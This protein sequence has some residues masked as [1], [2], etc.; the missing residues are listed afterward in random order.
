MVAGLPGAYVYRG[1]NTLDAMIGYRGEHEYLGKLAARLDDAANYVPARLAG[2]L[3]CAVAMVGERSG[4]SRG[5]GGRHRGRAALAE[6]RRSHGLS[7]SP[8]KMWTI[9]PMAGLLGVCLEK[10]GHCR[11]GDGDDR[12]GGRPLT[13]E[14]IGEASAVIW[15]A[16][17]GTLVAAALAAALRAGLRQ[18]KR[19]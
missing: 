5:R 11:I 1:I 2:G 6:L 7:D 3:L 16:G 15:K 8:N 4:A 14:V 17:A 18:G 13:P 19:C 10:P 9:A 12:D